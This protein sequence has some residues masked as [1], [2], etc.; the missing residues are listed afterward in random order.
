[1]SDAGRFDG[2]PYE[3]VLDDIGFAVAVFDRKGRLV[4]ASSPARELW[5]S[6]G[7]TMADD[8]QFTPG[9]EIIAEN[10]EPIATE[11]TPLVRVLRTGEAVLNGVYGLR[12][13]HGSVSWFVVSTV[14]IL[15]PETGD[16]VRVLC[17]YADVTE[18][19]DAQE[20]LRAEKERFEMLAE[21]ASDVIYRIELGVPPRVEYINPAIERLS[22]YSPEEFYADPS[23]IVTTVHEDDRERVLDVGEHALAAHTVVVRM[24]HR[25][26][27]ML[28]IE[29][30]R[31]PLRDA[32]GTVV[33]IEGIA[34][35]VT[36]LMEREAELAHRALHDPLTGLPN[37]LLL[38]DRLRS[39]LAR[40]RRHPGDLV[41]LYLDVDRF[42]PVNDDLGHD[43]GDRLLEV[44]ARRI[45]ETVRPSDT[46][47]LLGGDEF[48]VV[49][50]DLTNPGEATDIAERILQAVAEPLDVGT[51]ELVSTVSIGLAVAGDGEI[52]AAELLRRADVA[53]YRAKD[54]GRARVEHYDAL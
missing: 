46:V 47:A 27:R 3:R 36:G 51:G 28:W 18:L 45:A 11:D 40:T 37:R 15:D 30:Q 35:D 23:L 25:D 50:T 53:M 7:I 42:K 39:A 21:R 8:G 33:A 49:L 38:L 4:N 43:A 14:P 22:G 54:R 26:G 20:A 19:R 17:S 2:L 6:R 44:V 31:I 13:D 29:N 12:G 5:R 24:I 1:V 32:S 34:R 48:A 52:S 41:V 16:V 10:G 9:L